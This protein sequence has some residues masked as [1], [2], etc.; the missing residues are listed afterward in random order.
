MGEYIKG[1]KWLFGIFLDTSCKQV[2]LWLSFLGV[3]LWFLATP[4]L[5]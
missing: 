5:D 4:K 3:F 2:C 1:L